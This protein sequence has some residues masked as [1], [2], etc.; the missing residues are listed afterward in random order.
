MK[1]IGL[2]FLLAALHAKADECT[3]QVNGYISGLETATEMQN[4]NTEEKAFIQ[5]KIDSISALRANKADCEVRAQIP[6]LANS[7]AAIQNALNSM[8]SKSE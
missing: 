2:I 3:S 1:K 5:K 6:E 7:D 4:L 8:K